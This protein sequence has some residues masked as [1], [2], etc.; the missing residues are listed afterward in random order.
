[1]RDYS[2]HL[3]HAA[4]LQEAVD[5]G[6]AFIDKLSAI[7]LRS[8]IRSVSTQ[9]DQLNS[10]L[11]VIYYS[12]DSI[13]SI[14][15]GVSE[16]RN[17]LLSPTMRLHDE[18]LQDIFLHCKG[19]LVQRRYDT[20]DRPVFD[21]MILTHVSRRWRTVA[22][23]TASLWTHITLED[24]TRA[25]Y[26]PKSNP[27]HAFTPHVVGEGR[28]RAF[29]D[30]SKEA[31]L[32][33]DLLPSPDG[34]QL[35]TEELV[36][37]ATKPSRI[38]RL[39]LALYPGSDEHALQ[40]LKMVQ[41][42]VKDLWVSRSP[43]GMLGTQQQTKPLNGNDVFS[44]HWPLLQDL[45]LG[46]VSLPSTLT[47]PYI[48]L[49]N[50]RRL[51]LW[52]LGPTTVVA[53]MNVLQA[54]S[55][56]LEELDIEYGYNMETCPSPPA[57]SLPRLHHLALNAGLPLMSQF[58]PTIRAPSLLSVNLIFS[59]H[60]TITDQLSA[61]LS[62]F[63]RS[64]QIKLRIVSLVD[65]PRDIWKQIAE[66][67][68]NVCS[69]HYGRDDGRGPQNPIHDAHELENEVLQFAELEELVEHG[70][71]TISSHRNL[72]SFVRNR[73]SLRNTGV[74]VKTIRRMAMYGNMPSMGTVDEL[75]GLAEL[76]KELADEVDEFVIGNLKWHK[77]M[78]QWMPFEG[79]GDW[80]YMPRSPR[81]H[82]H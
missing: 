39:Q 9:D 24:G 47:T 58:L 1:M 68:P 17:R 67:V 34:Q 63:I 31:P 80:L 12:E 53:F 2:D 15:R 21:P 54:C 7:P 35:L 65:A 28:Q 5:A 82:V 64:S 27:W 10:I 81:R 6:R 52:R 38:E 18:L 22:L 8:S 49:P 41:G 57:L 16:I 79:G 4:K 3:R 59:G 76:Q 19:S 66:V 29:L 71:H 56:S 14:L 11:Q 13:E 78:K 25:R 40:S 60:Q 37:I 23:N 74:S 20:Y 26:R 46:G 48:R 43:I 70:H 42:T 50:I 75:K 36:R 77:T 72:L 73:K 51:R 61:V 44:A 30:R 62:S 33:V 45:K 32:S 69:I 55:G